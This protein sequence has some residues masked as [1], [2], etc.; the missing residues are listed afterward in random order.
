ML[1]TSVAA[2]A[3]AGVAFSRPAHMKGVDEPTVRVLNGSYAGLHSPEYDQDF[4]LGI[5]FAQPPVGDLRFRVPQSLNSTWGDVKDATAYAK[6]CVGYG[7]DQWPY[8]V[9]EDCLYLNI[10]RP[11]GY[12]TADLPVAIW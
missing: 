7:S 8:E 4:F 3:L 11:A 12:E 5:P 9:S 1:R 2:L 10:I 6:E